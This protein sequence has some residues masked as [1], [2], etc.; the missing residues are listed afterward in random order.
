M[1]DEP[2][3]AVIGPRLLAVISF[4]Q[5]SVIENRS[6]NRGYPDRRSTSYSPGRA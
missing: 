5:S 3:A 2:I 1:G 4:V 6:S